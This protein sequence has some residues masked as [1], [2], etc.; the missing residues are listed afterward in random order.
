MSIDPTALHALT[1][2]ILGCVCAQLTETARKVTGQ[3]GCPCRS[4][5][6]PGRP[7]WD[8]CDGPDTVEGAGGQLSV[9]VVRMFATTVEQFP[10]A[11]RNVQNARCAPT[12]LIAV[13]IGITLLRCA[14]VVDDRGYLPECGELSASA[15]VLH[16]DM[17]SVHN[18][19]MCCL[20]GLA[21]ARGR[22]PRWSLGSSRTVGPEGGCVGLDQLLTVALDSCPCPPDGAG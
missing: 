18:A 9:N 13:E 14:P 6:V 15:R 16:I 17:V 11:V 21:V 8:S 1:E 7:A 4:C 12:Q 19:L 2:G 10:E 20:P 22:G 5:V 3:P